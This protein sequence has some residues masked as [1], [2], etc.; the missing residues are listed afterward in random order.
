MKETILFVDD[1]EDILNVVN[2][3]FEQ[4][5]YH[6]I[7]ARNGAE[8]VQILE[9]E[10]IDC[11]FSDI[12]MPEM[13]GLQLAEYIRNYDNT[14]P[15]IIM[16]GYPSLDYTIRTLKNGVVDFL[17]KPVNLGQMELCVKRVLR[18]RELFIENLL[19]KEEV[20]IKER[21]ETVNREL[22]MKNEELHILN[23]IMSDFSLIGSSNDVFRRMV[24]MA[25]EITEADHA[26]FYIYND[27]VKKPIEIAAS[28]KTNSHQSSDLPSHLESEFSSFFVSQNFEQFIKEIVTE[29]MPVLISRNNG[30]TG[31][32][33]TIKSFM[34]VPLMIRDKRFG[35]L[36][37]ISDRT[38]KQFSE[39]EL[40]YLSFMTQ[41][42]A[43]SI[44]N[45]AL[46]ENIYENLFA[47]LFAF[48]KAIEAKD[49]YTEQHSNRVTQYAI[50]IAKEVGC[51]MEEI[52]ILNVAGRL[53]DIGKIGIQDRI[54]LKP[55][56]LTDSE[57]EIIKT[58]P[59]IG[60]NIVGQV[61]LWEREQNIIRH[62][63]EKYDGTG[64]PDRLKKNE[65]PFLARILTIADV[66]D[67]LASD[68]TYREKM[69]EK[70]IMKIIT[71]ESGKHFDPDLVD[72]FN[73]LVSQGKIEELELQHHNSDIK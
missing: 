57:Y 63:H 66:Y 5:G 6:V 23:R 33:D 58:H 55:G 29:S 17:I 70:N 61:G 72:I 56:K 13:D 54:L 2:E 39:K 14:I 1:E 43:Y 51:T 24:D 21:L 49:A 71:E 50:L 52:D 60:A 30:M 26:M 7:T 35:F 73:Q 44:E 8:A 48:V 11:C 9:K 28:T 36:I 19:L 45:L 20:K 10:K 3:F 22:S 67:A 18:E 37:S 16:T 69:A 15:V 46:Y 4:K 34:A 27:T 65:I 41:K 32:P 12:N 53:H 64:Y 40:Y 31:L 42:A 62:H 38:Q 47:T 59:V 68:R 25:I